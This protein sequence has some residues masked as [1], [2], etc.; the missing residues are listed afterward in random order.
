MGMGNFLM[1]SWALIWP[2][3]FEKSMLRVKPNNVEK[4][5][6]KKTVNTT[7]AF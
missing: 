2:F 1:L 4:I 5:S 6:D 7:F 3:I